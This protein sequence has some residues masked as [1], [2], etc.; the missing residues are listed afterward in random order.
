MPQQTQQD[1]PPKAHEDLYTEL[2]QGSDRTGKFVIE[3][4]DEYPE[5]ELE[6][7]PADKPTRNKL[8]R[9]MPSGLLDSVEIPD[10]IEDAEDITAEDIDLGD[11]SLA[12]MTFD[13]EATTIWLDEIS[14]HFTHDYFSESEVRNIFD[15]LDDEFLISAGSYIIELGASTGP[16]QGFRR[17]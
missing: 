2:M 17:E 14:E 7:L 3:T 13:E 8:R 16:V 9:T 4:D 11:L 1:G 12:D 10:N 5:I 15:R 6:V